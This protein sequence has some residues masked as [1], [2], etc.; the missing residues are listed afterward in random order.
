MNEIDM[1]EVKQQLQE[2]TQAYQRPLRGKFAVLMPL[3]DE[4]VELDRRGAASGEISAIL[5]QFKITVSKDTVSR[6]LREESRKERGS[7]A[8]RGGGEVQTPGNEGASARS[9]VP[10]GLPTGNE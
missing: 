8:K 5:A 7:R 1:D 2:F 9:M 6:F 3:K 10:R 4:I